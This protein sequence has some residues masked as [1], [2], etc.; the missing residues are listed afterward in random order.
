MNSR[1]WVIVIGMAWLI[2]LTF[3]GGYAWGDCAKLS[4]S[5]ERAYQWSP[6]GGCKINVSGIYV[7]RENGE[8]Q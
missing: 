2:S 8:W 4:L 3:S 7:P 5:I 1:T 6:V